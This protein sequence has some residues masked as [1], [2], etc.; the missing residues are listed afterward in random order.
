MTMVKIIQ[1]ITSTT[2]DRGYNEN[3][4]LVRVKINVAN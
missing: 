1:I 3:K 4:V 2:V